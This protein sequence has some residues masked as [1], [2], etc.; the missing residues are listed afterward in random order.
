MKVTMKNITSMR[1]WLSRLRLMPRIPAFLHVP[2]TGGTYIAQWESEDE[3]VISPLRY[4]GHNWVVQSLKQPAQGYPPQGFVQTYLVEKKSLAP[5][6]VFTTVRNPF[7]FFVSYLWHAGGLNPKYYDPNHYDFEAARKGFDYLLKTI[8]NRDE[9][10]PSRKLIHGQMF[11]DDGS[12][13]VDWINNNEVLDDDLECM[14][15]YLNVSYQ[16][17]PPQRVGR[18]DDYRTYYTEELVDMINTTWSREL[19]LFGYEFEGRKGKIPLLRGKIAR[20]QKQKIRYLWES[21]ELKINGEI[22]FGNN[23]RNKE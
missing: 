13:I 3:P 15:R 21:D 9:P 18:E 1:M 16:R 20:S 5:Y 10:W 6:F 19:D 17:R 12:L 7:S 14:A 4:L 23:D 11:C 2:K 22:Y 8:A